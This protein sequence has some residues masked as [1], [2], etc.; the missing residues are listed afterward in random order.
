[1]NLDKYM[2]YLN[3]IKDLNRYY[4]RV[5]KIIVIEINWSIGKNFVTTLSNRVNDKKNLQFYNN[6]I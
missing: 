3:I 5:N 4:F 6:N 2:I 1:M